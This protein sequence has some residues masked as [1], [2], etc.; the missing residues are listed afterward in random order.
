MAKKVPV[1]FWK[2]APGDS[3]AK[4]PRMS[5]RHARRA[6]ASSLGTPTKANASTLAVRIENVRMISVRAL[7]RTFSKS[8]TR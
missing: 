4:N 7:A 6:P 3:I 2:P 1:S 5:G 8:F